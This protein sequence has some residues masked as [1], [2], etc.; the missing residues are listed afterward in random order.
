VT[1]GTKITLTVKANSTTVRT[2]IAQGS[3]SFGVKIPG[4]TGPH[5]TDVG[6]LNWTYTVYGAGTAH[7]GAL[8]TAAGTTADGY[9]VDGPSYGY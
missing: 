8:G 5:A 4:T 3:V 2:G 7:T 6:G 1:Q 9:S